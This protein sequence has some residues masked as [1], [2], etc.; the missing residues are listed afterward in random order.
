MKISIYLIL[1]V[2]IV[3]TL[4]AA[5]QSV[6]F[7][8]TYGGKNEDLAKAVIVTKTGYMVI[9]R[10][11]S[12]RERRADMYIVN[13]DKKGNK[14]WS[15]AVG[16]RDDEEGTAIL[17]SDDGYLA[18]GTTES[19]GSDRS[20]IYAVKLDKS[21]DALWQKAYWSKDD[22]YYYGTGVAKTEKGF[23]I[24]GWENKLEFFDSE[25]FGYVVDADKEG[26]R[27][28]TRRYGGKD[29][30]LLYD[31]LK[32]DG[33]YILVGSSESF[34]DD[35][36]FDAYALKVDEA[37]KVLWQKIYGWGYD[38]SAYAVTEAKDG[39]FVLV[40]ITKSNR[41]KRDEVYVVRIDK[42]GKM[43]WQN[44]YGG[45]YDETGF[46][47]VADDDGYVITGMTETNTNGREDLYLLKIDDRGKLL[48]D[49]NYGGRD[50]DVGYG[51]AKTDD[52]YIIVGE[53]ESYG[54]GRK[55]A[56]I[57]KVNKKGLLK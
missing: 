28:R 43:L 48:W 14:I 49:R 13:M 44:S 23:K 30:D 15:K 50:S 3:T 53:T 16:G 12:H 1:P 42:D 11:N 9:G 25:V 20:S 47:I 17:Q 57:L 18:V 7:E 36:G 26:E 8:K 4:A 33:G 52:G 39:G 22:S 6:T 10:T 2:W 29:D 5:A 55:D 34:R 24:V 56:Y 38:E 31:I 41:D 46:D 54:N 21:G 27:I 40:G 32:T 19:F 45:R 35:Y 51:I 37:G